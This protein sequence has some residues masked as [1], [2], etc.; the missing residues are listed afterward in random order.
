MNGEIR[1]GISSTTRLAENFPSDM[2]VDIGFICNGDD[3]DDKT[4]KRS[5]LSK[6]PNK[7]TG[8]LISL[9]FGKK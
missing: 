6:K 2:T 8:Y 3:D 9:R 1:S 5:P 7:P 4:V